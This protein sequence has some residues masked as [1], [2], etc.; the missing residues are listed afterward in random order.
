MHD[1]GREIEGRLARVLEER[2]RP[3]VHTVLSPLTIEAWH[4]PVAADGRVGEPVAFAAARR[5]AYEP[6]Q[7]G[8]RWGPAWGTTWF[9]L[10]GE[11]PADAR[12]PEGVV[13]LGFTAENPGFQ[14][15]AL[16]YDAHGRTVKATRATPGCPPSP[17]S[18]SSGTSRPPPTRASSADG[19][20]PPRATGSRR[21]VSRCTR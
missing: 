3:A 21:L 7:V 15:E 18:G 19:S 6:A 5:A 8:L 1:R 4:V 14:A 11:V 13:D 2:I 9:R 10:T 16:V 17:A 20:R 12:W